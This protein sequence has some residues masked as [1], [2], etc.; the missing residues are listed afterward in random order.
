MHTIIQDNINPI[1]EVEKTSLVIAATIHGVQPV[2]LVNKPAEIR[3]LKGSILPPAPKQIASTPTNPTTNNN[4]K[5]NNNNSSNNNNNNNNT[6]QNNNKSSL[7]D[8][9]FFK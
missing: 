7:V 8:F 4:N 3:G 6:R 9:N 5:P 2:E 1:E